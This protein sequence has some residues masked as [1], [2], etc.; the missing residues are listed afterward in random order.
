MN[1]PDLLVVDARADEVGGQQVGRE[2]D[3]LELSADRS[4]QRVDRQRLGQS[5]HA[6]DQ[7]VALREHRD[8]HA[9]EKMVLADDDAS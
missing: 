4:R 8:Q 2:L 5:R 6:F 3:A 1:S 7:Q 9:L